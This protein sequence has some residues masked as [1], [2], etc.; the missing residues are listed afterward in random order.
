GTTADCPADGL[1]AAGSAGSPSCS[2]YLCG[3]ASS[4]CPATCSTSANCVATHM[5]SGGACVP[6]GLVGYWQLEESTGTTTAAASGHGNT[7]TITGATFTPSGKVGGARDFTAS[8]SKVAVGLSGFNFTQ[9]TIA[10]WY[11]PFYSTNNTVGVGH[12]MVIVGPDTFT[13]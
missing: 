8:G 4:S 13:H 11:R 2:P 12:S 3:G 10:F 1:A 6:N 7:G 9:G 5:C